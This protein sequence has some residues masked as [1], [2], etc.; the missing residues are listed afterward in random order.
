M[1]WR[2]QLRERIVLNA[3][4]EKEAARWVDWLDSASSSP[5][6]AGARP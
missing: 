1:P 2:E 3:S 4:I 5:R 6:A